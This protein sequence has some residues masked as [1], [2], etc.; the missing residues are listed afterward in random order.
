MTITTEQK[1]GLFFL[2][3][4]II[5]AVIIELVE[6]WDPLRVQNSYHTYFNSSVGLKVGDPVRMAGVAV[7]KIEE[8]SIDGLQVKVDFLVDEETE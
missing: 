8:I 5:L 1:V 6:D 4:L 7:G 2:F 3:A